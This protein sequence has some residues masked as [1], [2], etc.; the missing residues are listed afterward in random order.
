MPNATGT[1]TVESCISEAET[2]L[3]G[4][5]VDAAAVLAQLAQVRAYEDRTRMLGEVTGW[6][7]GG[8]FDQYVAWLVKKETPNG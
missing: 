2:L 1:G 3:K 5:N 7:A 6:G 8:T 4:G